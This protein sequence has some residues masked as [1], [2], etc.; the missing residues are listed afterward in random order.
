MDERKKGK[1]RRVFSSAAQWVLFVSS[2]SLLGF[3]RHTVL[4]VPRPPPR[5]FR[6]TSATTTTLLGNPPLDLA[7]GF[8]PRLLPPKGAAITVT[9]TSKLM[10]GG[11]QLLLLIS[12]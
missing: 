2:V 12:G 10:V 7:D 5:P 6:H 3:R 11:V 1:E 4:L 9:D 8:V